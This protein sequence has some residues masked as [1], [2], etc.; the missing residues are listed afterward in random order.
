VTNT[1]TY[2][3]MTA[4][5]NG[6]IQHNNSGHHRRA[7]SGVAPEAL[8]VTMHNGKVISSA[9]HRPPPCDADAQSLT[10]VTVH[11][12]YKAHS[13]AEAQLHHEQSERQVVHD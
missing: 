1:H 2:E 8:A 12:N 4:N 3:A 13:L 9:P 7:H 6:T 5:N 10:W 11:H